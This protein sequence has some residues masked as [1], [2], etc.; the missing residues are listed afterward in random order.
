MHTFKYNKDGDWILNEL[1]DGDD[2]LIQNLIHLLRTRAS[3]WIFNLNHGF[4]REIIEQKLPDKRQIVQAM[5]D[6]LYQEPRIA[7]VLSVEYEFD[8]IRRNL[9]IDFRART[10]NGTEVGGEANVNSSWIQT[11]E[12][13]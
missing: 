1:V 3:E 2:Q 13:S 10:T 4:R 7:E 9:R 6:C 12:N 5:H 11:N 8:R